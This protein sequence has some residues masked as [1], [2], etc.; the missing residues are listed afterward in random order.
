M[1]P[2]KN[3]VLIVCLVLLIAFTAVFFRLDSL[4][5]GYT[6][7]DVRARLTAIR[8]GEA[9]EQPNAVQRPIPRRQR[10][11]TVQGGRLPERRPQKLH[12][13]RALYVS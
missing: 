8:R 9:P 3:R 11:Y 2:Y 7:A 5:D 13:F 4:G 10:R 6:E 1:R 12:G